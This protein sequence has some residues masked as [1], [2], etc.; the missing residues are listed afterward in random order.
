MFVG[1]DMA[2]E[3]DINMSVVQEHFHGYPHLLPILL[4]H[5]IRIV[6]RRVDQ[7]HHPRGHL[8]INLRQV[9][10][11]TV[12][13]G[14]SK[15]IARVLPQHYDVHCSPGSV[16]RVVEIRGGATELVGHTP[17]SVVRHI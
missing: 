5:L 14:R 9:F 15:S 8:P 16:E 3:D 10:Y 2:G 7:C 1:V 17:P 12:V 6:P 13:L 4:M 11:E